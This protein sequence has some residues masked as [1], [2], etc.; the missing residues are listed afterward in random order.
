MPGSGGEGGP[1]GN[2][3]GPSGVDPPVWH[4]RPDAMTAVPPY[5]GHS[6]HR[7]RAPSPTYNPSAMSGP[8]LPDLILYGRPDCGLC[9]EAREMLRAL[10]EERRA[11]GLATPTLREVDIEADPAL[12]HAFFASIPVVELGDRRLETV[13]SLTKLRRLLAEVLDGDT[14]APS[15]PTAATTV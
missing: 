5:G 14:A 8:P 2:H 1:P 7:G 6:C 13:T 15:S 12:E 9:V 3:N 10:F 11:N 4:E